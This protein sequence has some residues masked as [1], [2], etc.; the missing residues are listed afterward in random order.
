MLDKD[1]I[2]Y[3]R[4]KPWPTYGN[5]PASKNR[6]MDGLEAREIWRSSGKDGVVLTSMV[7]TAKAAVMIRSATRKST[8]R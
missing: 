5:H 8:A 1:K 2:L 6:A 4:P 7:K 3:L